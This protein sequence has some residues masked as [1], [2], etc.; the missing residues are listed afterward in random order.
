MKTLKF[1]PELTEKILTGEK[2]STWRLFDD[3]DL[4]GGDE[5]I[6]VNKETGKAFGT[7]T[8]INLYTKTLGTLEDKDWEGHERFASEEEMYATYRTYY[9]DKVNSNSEVKVI[10]FVFKPRHE[11]N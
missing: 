7:A 3:K 9:G 4:Q 8:I 10:T 11:N 5:L 2:T 1:T 6:F